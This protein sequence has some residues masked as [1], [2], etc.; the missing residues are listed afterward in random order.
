M[1]SMVDFAVLMTPGQNVSPVKSLTGLQRCV[2]GTVEVSEQDGPSLRY[3]Q[4]PNL[5]T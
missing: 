1:S 4:V 5:L 3:M 2:A